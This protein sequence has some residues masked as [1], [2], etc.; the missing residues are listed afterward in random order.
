MQRVLAGGWLACLV[1]AAGAC[2]GVVG[3]EEAVSV[4]FADLVEQ[5]ETYDGSVVCTKG[6]YVS[7]FE[8]SGLGASTERRGGSVYLTEPVIWVEGD[9]IES[10]EDCVSEG[11]HPAFTFC[12][13][14]VCGVFECGGGHGHLGGY[15][16]QVRPE[17]KR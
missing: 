13:A 14:R 4:P 2:G 16:C 10:T 5:A 17:A 6:T 7:G 11:E 15:R 9:V 12:E 8:V 3:R 1:A